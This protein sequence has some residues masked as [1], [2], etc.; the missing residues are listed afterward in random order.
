MR[1]IVL[2]GSVGAGVET[3]DRT[4]TWL[5][6]FGMEGKLMGVLAGAIGEFDFGLGLAS[7]PFMP[8]Q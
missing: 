4:P 5:L 1:L 3:F 2:I 7:E 6:G 8:S